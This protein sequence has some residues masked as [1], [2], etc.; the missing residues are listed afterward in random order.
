M[1]LPPRYVFCCLKKI[2]F[3]NVLL[4]LGVAHN[5][6]MLLFIDFSRNWKGVINYAI[7]YTMWVTVTFISHESSIL[8]EYVDV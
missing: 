3:S 6:L 7:N 1:L 2:N 5:Y 4:R 8:K